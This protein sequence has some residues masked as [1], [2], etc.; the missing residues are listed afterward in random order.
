[1]I[2]HYAVSEIGAYHIKNKTVCQ[3]SYSYLKISEHFAIG[4]VADGLGSEL[5]S[6][7]ASEMACS[8]S[9]AYCREKIKED[10]SKDQILQV[11]KESFHRALDAINQYVNEHKEDVSQ[12]DTTLSLAVYLNGNVY[13]GHSGDSGIIILN[14]DGTYEALTIKQQD[15]FGCVYPLCSGEKKWVFGYKNKVGSVLLATDGLFD[16]FFPYLLKY[17]PNKS[18]YVLLAKYFMSNDSLQFGDKTENEV[19][20]VVREYIENIP[21]SQVNDDKTILLMMDTSIKPKV[22]E[23]EYYDAPDWEKL[24]ALYNAEFSKKAYPSL[25]NECAEKENEDKPITLEETKKL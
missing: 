20:G 16:I 23:K 4:V 13:Y 9:I 5:H 3:D 22:L 25:N 21:E 10:Y 6:E 17:A 18:I 7:V 8:V 12:Y 2:Y 14:E 15:D 11:I 24:K 1:M 19:E